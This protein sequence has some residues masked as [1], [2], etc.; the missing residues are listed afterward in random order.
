MKNTVSGKVVKTLVV[1]TV[2]LAVSGCSLLSVP[3]IRNASRNDRP[4]SPYR[5]R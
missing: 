2:L 3:V 5:G 1:F 4:I